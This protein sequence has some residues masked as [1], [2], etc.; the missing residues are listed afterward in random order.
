MPYCTSIPSCLL[1]TARPKRPYTAFE[2]ETDA[3]KIE[4]MMASKAQPVRNK[5]AQAQKKV[6]GAMASG[7]RTSGTTV[8]PDGFELHTAP[9]QTSH[10]SSLPPGEARAELRR[11]RNRESAALSRERARLHTRELEETVKSL[12]DR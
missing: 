9:N 2:D 5:P 3:V 10:E 11:Q 8:S 7:G 4:P 1:Q 12:Q 6:E